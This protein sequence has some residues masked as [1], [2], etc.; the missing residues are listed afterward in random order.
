M[1]HFFGI[2]VGS[3]FIKAAVL[4]VDTLE[5]RGIERAPFPEFIGGLPALYREAD[6]LAVLNTVEA[7]L[8]RLTANA[9]PCHGLVL[10]GQM[11]GFVLMNERGDAVSNYISWLDQRVT[12]AEFEELTGRITPAER[13]ETG[14]E[15]RP[16]IALPALS[17]LK[18]HNALPVGEATPVS[19]ADFV[20]ARLAGARAVLDPTQAAAFGALRIDRLQ[21]HEEIIGKLG[22]NSLRWADVRP[23]GV[24]V[25][26]WR[27]APCYAAIGDQQCALAGA[28]L[29]EGELSVN[30]GTGSQVAMLGRTG[31]A[32]AHQT[33]PYF[34]GGYLRTITH[35]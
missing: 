28:L 25:G 5:L 29:R 21:W 20:A 22:L 2:D 8:E 3:S 1:A 16:S 23:S 32:E 33:R 18:R 6:P 14:N 7:L 35:I 19:I 26:A 12:P 13:G 10:C 9:D 4:D 31:G 34:D 17:W 15:L 30:I 24:V 27:G 11:H